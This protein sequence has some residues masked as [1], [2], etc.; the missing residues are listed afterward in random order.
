MDFEPVRMMVAAFRERRDYVLGRL[1]A[2]DGVQCPKPEGAFYLFPQVS[3][4]YG[5]TTPSGRSIDNSED[6]CFYLL[7]EHNVALVPGHAFGGPDGVRLSYAASMNDLEEALNRIETGEGAGET[8][9][10]SEG[11][12]LLPGLANFPE[13]LDHFARGGEAVIG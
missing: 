7:E 4:Y 12:G 6:L 5:T 2:I 13:V 11:S 9:Y 3:A 10:L 8:G 1:V